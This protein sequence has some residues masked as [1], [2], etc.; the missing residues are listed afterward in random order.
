MD[1]FRRLLHVREPSFTP[2]PGTPPDPEPQYETFTSRNNEEEGTTDAIRGHRNLSQRALTTVL[3]QF[4]LVML[5]YIMSL[6]ITVVSLLKPLY[7]IKDFYKKKSMRKSDPKSRLNNLLEVLNS[8]SERT[9]NLT[10]SEEGPIKYS[11]GSLYDLENGSLCQDIIQGSYTELLT[12]CSEQCKFAIIYLHDPILDNSTEYVNGLLCTEKF[13]TLVKKYQVLLWFSD[14]TTSEGLQV[15]NALKV[16]KFPFL[17]VLCLKAENKIE[18]FGK[19]EGDLNKYNTNFLENVL[20]KGY[21]RLIQIRQQRQ[22]VALQQLI[23]EQQDSRYD[24]SLRADQMRERERE[25]Q[26]SR[27]NDAQE[28]ER[29]RMLWL[30]WRKTQLKPEPPSDSE[31]PV[32]RVAIRTDTSER[33]V[34]RFDASLPIEEIYAFVELQRTYTLNTEEVY[35]FTGPPVGYQHDYKFILVS[36][37]PRKE[38]A[39]STVIREESAIFPSGSIIIETIA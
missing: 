20:G 34:R 39:P 10:S 29:L 6:T 19:M 31:T 25:A 21:S 28:Q 8:E 26:R 7:A 11:F 13:A 17:G 35:S 9:L 22:N 32:C 18:L 14:V 3:L 2:I 1:L 38:L 37:A 36:P 12:T 27:E 16:R 23:R 30:L 33:I 5:Y 24:E 15:A 4:P